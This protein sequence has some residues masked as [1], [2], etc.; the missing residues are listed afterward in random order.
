M[1][2]PDDVDDVDN[3]E[4]IET[5][6]SEAEHEFQPAQ[7][8]CGCHVV[9]STSSA[10]GVPLLGAAGLLLL[11][12]RRRYAKVPLG[13]IGRVPF[14]KHC[15][16][17]LLSM[18]TMLLIVSG[19]LGCGGR[20][21]ETGTSNSVPEGGDAPSTCVPVLDPSVVA[22]S[23]THIT[24]GPY[25]VVAPTSSS[26]LAPDVSR[27]HTPFDVDVL[28]IPS[29]LQYKPTRDG[30]HALFLGDAEVELSLIQGDVEV[31]TRRFP[32]GGCD[33]VEA[34]ISAELKTGES[35][36]FIFRN[37]GGSPFLLFVEH[38]GT[39]GDTAWRTACE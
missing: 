28:E 3:D 8:S 9:G 13:K 32:I 26:S 39:F 2:P 17:R 18:F 22:H 12:F 29:E 16:R 1:E 5:P 37:S 14:C 25:V 4:P 10:L 6:D 20:A 24:N 38:L 19:L 36:R 30:E 35:Y 33:L 34:G 31:P 7:S 11:A 27:V 15:K 21:E 23:C